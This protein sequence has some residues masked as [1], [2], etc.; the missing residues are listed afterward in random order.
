M[1][2]RLVFE[3]TYLA[4]S[5]GVPLLAL[6]DGVRSQA[7]EF[8]SCGDAFKFFTEM[9]AKLTET[10]RDTPRSTAR[11]A[12]DGGM[13]I[14]PTEYD[15]PRSTVVEHTTDPTQFMQVSSLLNSLT[16]WILTSFL[17]AASKSR[18]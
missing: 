7:S 18:P 2:S 12:S 3:N 10:P 14:T 16:V 4:E 6:T 1:L 9:E 15:S 11:T 5:C 13:S 8:Q 17:K